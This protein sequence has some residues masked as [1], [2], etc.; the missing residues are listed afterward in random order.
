MPRTVGSRGLWA[1]LAC[2]VVAFGAV[3]PAHG[4]LGKDRDKEKKKAP[5]KSAPAAPVAPPPEAKPTE[6]IADRVLQRSRGITWQATLT[7]ELSA[8]S[9]RQ[10]L[11]GGAVMETPREFKL[12]SAAIVFPVLK[13][14]STHQIAWRGEGQ[15]VFD[16]TLRWNESPVNAR[17]LMQEGFAGGTRLARW[18]LR[19]VTGVK[20]TLEIVLQVNSFETKFDEALA[21]TMP[22]PRSWPAVA[23]STFTPQLFVEHQSAE[24]KALLGRFVEA[25]TDPKSRPPVVLAKWLAG[26][27]MEFYKPTG[28]GL[29]ANENGTL[30]GFELR[31]A[32]AMAVDGKGSPHDLVC[33]LAAV[34]KAAGL[35][36]RVVIGID[37][38][39]NNSGVGLGNKQNSSLRSWVEFCLV[40]PFD[41]K[42]LWVPVDIARMRRSGN[43]AASMEQSWKFFGTHDEL[44]DVVPIAFQFHPPANVAAAAPMFWG[45]VTNPPLEMRDQSFRWT[46]TRAAKS[47]N[48]PVVWRK[49]K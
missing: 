2:G 22:W 5:A 42:E 12:A 46:V 29:F 13:Q 4:Q 44:R 3:A 38:G 11:K 26:Q 41:N 49:D 19:D 35:P 15:E 34:Y 24:V 36:A 17:V 21:A 20:A 48:D 23:Q 39:R 6:A 7:Q 18:E 33:L 43:R 30:K 25:G 8:G 27:V 47:N 14:S 45:L 1:W 9:D 31:G 16:S 37:T 28:T 40:D 10:A 32:K